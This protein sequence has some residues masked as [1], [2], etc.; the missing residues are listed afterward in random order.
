MNSERQFIANMSSGTAFEAE[1]FAK[2][3]KRILNEVRISEKLYN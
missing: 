1:S 3:L 2:V